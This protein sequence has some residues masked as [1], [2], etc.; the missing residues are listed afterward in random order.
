MSRN[1]DIP[2]EQPDQS[3]ADYIRTLELLAEISDKVLEE[4]AYELEPKVL[5]MAGW[6]THRYCPDRVIEEAEAI[7]YLH[8]VPTPDEMV[9]EAER[10]LRIAANQQANGIPVPKPGPSRF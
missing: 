10:V 1:P 3:R 6:L 5:N 4:Q 7:T 9:K 8:R 2:A